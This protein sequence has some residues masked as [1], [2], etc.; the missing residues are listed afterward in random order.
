MINRD[1]FYYF[2]Y[3][4]MGCHVPCCSKKC[5]KECIRECEWNECDEFLSNADANKI[6]QKY[7]EGIFVEIP[8][9]ATNGEVINLVFPNEVWGREFNEKWMKAPY[10]K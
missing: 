9:G 4:D 3:V 2:E 7:C 5:S 8:E 1:C 10:R 6:I